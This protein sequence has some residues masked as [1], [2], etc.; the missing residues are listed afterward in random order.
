MASLKVV[1]DR[2]QIHVAEIIKIING[3][4]TQI[5]TV[6]VHKALI[7]TINGRD[8]LCKMMSTVI[9]ITPLVIAL[10]IVDHPVL[11]QNRETRESIALKCS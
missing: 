5:G 1:I 2:T 9:S 3:H 4:K 10:L 7:I 8:P 11:I 6:S